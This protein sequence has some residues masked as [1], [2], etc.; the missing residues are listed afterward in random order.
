MSDRHGRGVLTRLALLGGSMCSLTC[1]EPS[2]ASTCSEADQLNGVCAIDEDAADAE[3]M[4]TSLIQRRLRQ[5][6]SLSSGGRRSLAELVL[7]RDLQAYDESYHLPYSGGLHPVEYA[8]ENFDVFLISTGLVH[9]LTYKEKHLFKKRFIEAITVA[10]KHYS[11][12]G[13]PSTDHFQYFLLSAKAFQEQKPVVS[14]ASIESLN[15]AQSSWRAEFR[16]QLEDFSHQDYVARLG[17]V[18]PLSRNKTLRLQEARRMP[19]KEMAVPRKFDALAEW[20]HCAREIGRVLNQGHCG[21][22]WAFGALGAADARLCIATGAAYDGMSAQLS[23]GYV[24]SCSTEGA[25][26]E[27]GLSSHA[28]DFLSNFGA[29]TGGDKGC[30]PY[31]ATGEGTEHFEK[32]MKEPPCPSHCHSTYGRTLKEDYF[33]VRGLARYDELMASPQAL[34][35]AKEAIL[36]GGPVPFGLHA[37]RFFMAYTSGVYSPDPRDLPNHETVAHGWGQE[38]GNAYILAQNSWGV[39][40][41]MDGRFKISEI[42][43]TDWTIPGSISHEMSGYPLPLPEVSNITDNSTNSSPWDWEPL[44]VPTPFPTPGSAGDDDATARETTEGCECRQKWQMADNDER[45][46]D[47][48]CN[49]DGDPLGEWCFVVDLS[50]QGTNWGYC[51]PEKPSSNPDAS[52]SHPWYIQS[53]ACTI[54]E[55]GC[56]LSPNFPKHYHNKEHCRIGVMPTD[57]TEKELPAI[58]EKNYTFRTEAIYDSVTVNGQDFSGDTT[59]LI[60]MVPTAKIEWSSDSDKTSKGWRL[61][62]E[63]VVA[64]DPSPSRIVES[65]WS[66]SE[67]DCSVDTDGCMLSPNFPQEYG[68]ADKCVFSVEDDAPK[69][70]VE[71]FDTEEGFDTLSVNG[72]EY[73]GNGKDLSGVEPWMP[74]TWS[75]DVSGVGKGFKICPGEAGD[76]GYEYHEGDGEEDGFWTMQRCRCLRSWVSDAGVRCDTYCCQTG[77]E[78]DSTAGPWCKV[79]DEGCEQKD[80]GYCDMEF[81]G[82]G[83]P[84]ADASYGLSSEEQT[85]YDDEEE[86]DNEV[87]DNA[88]TSNKPSKR[89]YTQRGCICKTNW[90]SGGHN[91]RDSCCNPDGDDSGAWCIVERNSCEGRN[92]G[93]C[94]SA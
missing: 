6:Q 85:E 94:T 41:G 40:W 57:L 46:D 71:S 72:V 68:V 31:F 32:T 17:K 39:D 65:K 86:Q 29:P 24:T 64:P 82:F 62:P 52:S 56:M 88:K 15:R 10:T 11:A 5:D 67:G 22:C 76:P 3:E 51:S 7:E 35:R 1:S 47:F 55:D 12:H 74:I 18:Q 73:S 87:E 81:T 26:C 48:C 93:Y 80:W 49:P 36:R 38:G 92:F 61:C 2:A 25:G 34:T 70:V 13:L 33:V 83:P 69:M 14:Q 44:P 77:E 30:I 42:G 23:R 20:P 9:E 45:C 4:R 28:F 75:S 79:Q 63:Y 66:V 27:G 8:K 59:D 84:P 91:C 78:E 60:G 90:M 54:D 58:S 16:I 43:V 37:S 19:W 89:R 21:S 50:C 53:G